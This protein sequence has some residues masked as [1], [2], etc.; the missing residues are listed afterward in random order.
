VLNAKG[1]KQLEDEWVYWLTAEDRAKQEVHNSMFM[2]NNYLEELIKK[3]YR[4]PESTDRDNPNLKFVTSADMLD[5]IST[6]SVF[7]Q[8]FSNKDVSIVMD[9]LGFTKQHRRNGNGWW[10]V[11][12]E[13]MVINMEAGFGYEREDRLVVFPD[14]EETEKEDEN[15]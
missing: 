5:K 14:Q 9:R 2:V 11:E 6:N 3:Y 8:T 12:K 7:R 13:G 4:V 15:D 10:V 1:K